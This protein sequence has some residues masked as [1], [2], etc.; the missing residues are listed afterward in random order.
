MI[1]KTEMGSSYFYFQ[2]GEA[3]DWLDRTVDTKPVSSRTVKEGIDE[4]RRLKKLNQ[5]I[6]GKPAQ[7]KA[8]RKRG[9]PTAG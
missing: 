3:S 8:E 6:I 1:M 9:S 4:F 2:F 5:Q 7:K